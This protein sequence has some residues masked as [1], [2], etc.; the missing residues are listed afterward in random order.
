MRAR[1]VIPLLLASGLAV[2]GEPKPTTIDIKALRDQFIVLEDAQGGTYAVINDPSKPRLWYAPSAKAKTFYEQVVT[3]SS[4]NGPNAFDI[5]VWAPRV[6]KIEPGS[7]QRNEEGKF[8]RWCGNDSKIPLTEVKAD[9]AKGVIDKAT[10]MTTALTRR[11]HLLARDDGGTY[12]YV[13]I[14]R[15]QYGGSGYRV[16]AGKKGAMKQLPLSDVATDTAGEVFATK[17]GDVRIVHDADNT[18][19][20]NATWV[21]G[22]KR[23]PLVTLDVD[24]NSHLIFRDL[25][26]YSFLGTICDDL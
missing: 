15:E 11:A 9:R 5:S 19:K 16:F 3:G 8:F 4:Q 12:Y 24:A 21:K 25:G 6:P 20:S 14:I 22:E 18:T 23:T 13:D 17:S 26:V 2:A 10:F 7:I 1:R